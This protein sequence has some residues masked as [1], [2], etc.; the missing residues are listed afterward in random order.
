VAN[1]TVQSASHNG[2]ATATTTYAGPV[3]G[4]INEGDLIDALLV[5]NVDGATTVS[6]PD[7]TWTELVGGGGSYAT[8][9]GNGYY[10][11]W[12]EVT[13]AEAASPPA[14]WDFTLGTARTG[15]II[16][17][18]TTGHLVGDP[19]NTAVSTV[20]GSFSDSS[21]LTIPA[22]TTDV[23]ECT[24]LGFANVQSA[25]SRTIDEPTSPG[26]WTEDDSS[27]TE[28]I[29]RGQDALS[30]EF[31]SAGSTGDV[32]VYQSGSS[33]PGAAGMIAVQPAVGGEVAAVT[34]SGGALAGGVATIEFG[35]VVTGSGGVLA[36]GAGGVEASTVV[37]GSGRVL[38]GGA[39]GLTAAVVAPAA[40]GVLV[41][42]AADVVANPKAAVTG[43]GG[44]LVG[45]AAVVNANPKATVTGSGGVVV[46]G[47]G[48]ATVA[49]IPSVTGGVVVGGAATVA[50]GYTVTGSG[51]IV[52]GGAADYTTPSELFSHVATGGILTSGGGTSA[53]SSP[54]TAY[55]VGHRYWTFRYELLDLDN[56]FVTDLDNVLT[57]KVSM[58]WLAPIR[59]KA[60]FVLVESDTDIDWLTDR[61]KPW[62]RLHLPPYGT[63]DWV[64]WPLGVFLLSS[65]TRTVD[66]SGVVVR[67][68]TGYDQLQ[69]LD[70]DKIGDRY[71]VAAGATHTDE[72]LTLLGGDFAYRL[73]ARAST[74]R[75]AREWPP[76]T[77]KLSMVND[78]LGAINYSAL[79]F[80]E[81]GVAVI[82]P[83]VSPAVRT[84][85]YTY[86][87]DETSL[88]MPD[89]EQEL[90]LFSV[91]NKWVLVVSNPDAD[92]LVSTYTNDNPASPT[93]TVRRGRTITDYREEEEADSQADLD[94]KAER[95]AL[96]AS[97]IYE[98]VRFTTG[99][100]PL[101]SGN[102]VYRI[103][104]SGL[105][106]NSK[107]SETKWEMELRAGAA[108]THEAR[109]LVSI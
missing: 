95:L 60:E 53:T 28:S 83:Y 76:G 3:P 98:H 36:G 86:A 51:G 48:A 27:C 6:M 54:R 33:L 8:S 107:F 41:G 12:H 65:P 47:D 59:R 42:G 91:A 34:G 64:E 103:A 99:I 26:T 104:L 101:H 11:A 13:A 25:S 108:M 62:A 109:R 106:V 9:G 80:D 17:R 105:A 10:W 45:G 18:R 69:V 21:P 74:T 93:S 92:L 44:V 89:V 5:S 46:G 100:N 61:I 68:V 35:A 1:P 71:T 23:D 72:V 19:F 24:L 58:S 2:Y 43:S 90:D 70:D 96:S 14:S 32:D 81:D 22:V 63:D 87:D 85:E 79:Y 30:Y 73:T 49:V 57:G 16:I 77:S 52:L 84:E 82:A 50:A 15:N 38:V 7:G 40:G 97:Q 94:A 37:T 39:A 75:V 66:A 55:A 20:S 29:G 67:H 4:T 31:G 102:D 56:E 78:L 88:V